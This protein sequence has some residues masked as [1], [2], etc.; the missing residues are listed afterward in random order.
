MRHEEAKKKIENFISFPVG[1]YSHTANL[2]KSSCVSPVLPG[3]MFRMAHNG[4]VLW[5]KV[6]FY[7]TWQIINVNAD[8]KNLLQ[9]S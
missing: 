3:N 2:E 7:Y 6:H 9:D 5:L 4:N 8:L 1:V